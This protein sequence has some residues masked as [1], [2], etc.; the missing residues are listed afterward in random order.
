MASTACAFGLLLTSK[1]IPKLPSSWPG[2][3]SHLL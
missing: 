3:L 2:E 1:A